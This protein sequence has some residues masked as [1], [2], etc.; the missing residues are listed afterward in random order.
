MLPE[1][2]QDGL[3]GYLRIKGD[4]LVCTECWAIKPCSHRSRVTIT[5]LL[6]ESHVGLV[7]SIVSK[8][9]YHDLPELLSEGLLILTECVRNYRALTDN[10]ISPYINTCVRR[11]IMRFIRQ[12]IM[13]VTV[14]Y[15]A[16]AK[17]QTIT[18]RSGAADTTI[19]KRG[20][21]TLSVDIQDI[22]EHVVKD[23]NE[24]IIAECLI[25]GG[26]TSQ[27]MADL[28]NLSRSR[29]QAIKADV[30]FRLGVAWNG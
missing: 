20:D 16:Y 4:A 1:E 19:D 30:A 7:Q 13:Q 18:L 8:F 22:V 14:D 21:A 10:N 17:G 12:N 23:N 2:V 29:A 27:D 5:R 9:T 11:G 24:K 15:R 28:C 3:V 26:Y 6:I 25:G